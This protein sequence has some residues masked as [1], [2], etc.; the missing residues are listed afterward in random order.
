MHPL[1]A[2]E[3]QPASL[4]AVGTQVHDSHKTFWLRKPSFAVPDCRLLVAVSTFLLGIL[5]GRHGVDT[6]HATHI[7][8]VAWQS[9]MNARRL[10]A[11]VEHSRH[12]YLSRSG[13]ERR[14]RDCALEWTPGSRA[15]TQGHPAAERSGA[16][17]Q[18]ALATWGGEWNRSHGKGLYYYRT[19]GYFL[20]QFLQAVPFLSE[21]AR[22]LLQML[23]IGPLSLLL[24]GTLS[25]CTQCWHRHQ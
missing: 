22:N 10:R 19:Y 14:A 21:N 2:A 18:I 8:A 24:E 12:A 5:I 11:E 1:S 4:P 7:D 17:Y 9:D 3:D 13:L 25:V 23:E 16:F 15:A 20:E 6:T